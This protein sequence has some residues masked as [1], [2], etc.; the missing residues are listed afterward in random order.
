MHAKNSN[1]NT[2]VCSR[3]VVTF[4]GVEMLLFKFFIKEKKGRG[5]ALFHLVSQHTLG[6][7]DLVKDMLTH[8]GVH[9]RERI[10]QQVDI[11]FPVDS[12]SQT[13]PLFLTS[14]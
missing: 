2:H 1:S 10:I 13:H 4:I 3:I 7:D 5:R 14:R 12:T 11:R 8:V 6:P 9:S